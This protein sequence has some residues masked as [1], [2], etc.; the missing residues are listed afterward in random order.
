LSVPTRT[1]AAATTTRSARLVVPEQVV[2]RLELADIV[3]RLA[4]RADGRIV[5]E[6]GH[7]HVA[8]GASRTTRATATATTRTIVLDLDGLGLAARAATATTARGPLLALLGVVALD[9]AAAN[10]RSPAPERNASSPPGHW[11]ASTCV[12]TRSGQN[13]PIVS[14]SSK[15]KKLRFCVV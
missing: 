11:G 10:R 12:Y 15:S 14:G 2:Y 13:A 8:L 4:E 9:P 6:L 7:R 5:I 3:T 1:T